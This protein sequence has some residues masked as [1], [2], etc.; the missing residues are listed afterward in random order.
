MSYSTSIK[1]LVFLTKKV[2]IELDLFKKKVA[3][4]TMNTHYRLFWLFLF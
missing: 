4:A 1:N 2:E 3:I